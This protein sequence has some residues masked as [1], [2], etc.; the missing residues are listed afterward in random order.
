MPEGFNPRQVR[1][2][3]ATEIVDGCGNVLSD[4]VLRRFDGTSWVP[5]QRAEAQA[6]EADGQK[7]QWLWEAE[8]RERSATPSLWVVGPDA[9]TSYQVG[10]VWLLRE[11]AARRA[12]FCYLCG[13]PLTARHRCDTHRAECT[14]RSCLRR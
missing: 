12:G 10:D 2:R 13:E 6:I 5:V 8:I 4:G 7:V 3:D 11:S 9:P 14:C 1:A